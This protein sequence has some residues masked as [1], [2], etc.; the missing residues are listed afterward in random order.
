MISHLLPSWKLENLSLEKVTEEGE[1]SCML[2]SAVLNNFNGSKATTFVA[3]KCT[4]VSSDI[5]GICTIY[6]G[7]ALAG[8]RDLGG[9]LVLE[10]GERDLLGDLDRLRGEALR[11]RRSRRSLSRSLSRWLRSRS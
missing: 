4:Y 5:L 8:R 1:G 10:D 11:S 6:L 7:T 2:N 3:I 9:L